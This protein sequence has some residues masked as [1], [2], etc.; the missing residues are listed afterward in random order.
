MSELECGHCGNIISL[1][2]SDSDQ[3]VP[4]LTLILGHP[5]NLVFVFH[6]VPVPHDRGPAAAAVDA[7]NW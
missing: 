6:S 7:T 1:L 4:T 5:Q 3:L 2:V